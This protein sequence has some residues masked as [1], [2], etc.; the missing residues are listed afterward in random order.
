MSESEV[1]IHEV[2]SEDVPPML[3]YNVNVLQ[4]GANEYARFGSRLGTAGTGNR[5]SPWIIDHQGKVG[6]TSTKTMPDTSKVGSECR[7]RRM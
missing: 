1:F 7:D 4:D 3:A 6:S 2:K 5:L